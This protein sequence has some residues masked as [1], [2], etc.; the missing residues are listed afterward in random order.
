MGAEMTTEDLLKKAVA[1]FNAL[2]PE[3][4]AEMIEEQRRS[5]AKGNVA[6]SQTHR[7]KRYEKIKDSLNRKGL[8]KS[9]PVHRW[10]YQ[11]TFNAIAAATRIEGGGIAVSVEKFAEA[12]G[13]IPAAPVSPH[14]NGRTERHLNDGRTKR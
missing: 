4:Q 1:A 12:F 5:F 7:P 10:P 11:Q 13:P 6:L 8:L 9:P 3:Q 14:T 2:S